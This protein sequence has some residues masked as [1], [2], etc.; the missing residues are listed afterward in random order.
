MVEF[1]EEILSAKKDGKELFY[2]DSGSKLAYQ[3][4]IKHISSAEYL[5][6]ADTLPNGDLRI[7]KD[8]LLIDFENKKIIQIDKNT[9]ITP[10]AL[11][12]Y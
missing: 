11:D 6:Y 9:L 10:I 8:F 7:K 2:N 1:T 3:L 5:G 12:S 4:G